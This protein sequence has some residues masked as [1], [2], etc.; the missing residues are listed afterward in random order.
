LP[1]FL[2]TI[3]LGLTLALAAGALPARSRRLLR[4]ALCAGLLFLSLGAIVDC[5]GGGHP[6]A[7][8]PRTPAGDYTITVTGTYGTLSLNTQVVLTVR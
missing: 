5:G 4:S 1:L 7:S 2:A 6:S 3:G 8:G